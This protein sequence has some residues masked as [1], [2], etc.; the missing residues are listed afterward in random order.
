MQMLGEAGRTD[1]QARPHR[2]AA[3]K[4]FLSPKTVD[5]TFATSTSGSASTPAAD[6]AASGTRRL[7]IICGPVMV[8]SGMGAERLEQLQALLAEATA[9]L[10]TSK[11][12]IP[13]PRGA[14]SGV[15]HHRVLSGSRL[16]R[17]QRYPRGRTTRG[18]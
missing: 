17:Q 12:A 3:A 15:P 14:E 11:L 1:V 7:W 9:A 2:L 4:P 8:Y 5:T 6:A 10:R 18:Q 13:A 16:P